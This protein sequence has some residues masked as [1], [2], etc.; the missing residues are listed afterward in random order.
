MPVLV[1]QLEDACIAQSHTLSLQQGFD[2][3]ESMQRYASGLNQT[4]GHRR[5][6]RRTCLPL[7]A[8]VLEWLLHSRVWNGFSATSVWP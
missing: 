8:D 1:K 4:S 7:T 5:F 6:V 3:V 2:V